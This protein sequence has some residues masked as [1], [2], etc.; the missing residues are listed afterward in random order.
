[1]AYTNDIFL[2]GISDKKV[3]EVKTRIISTKYGL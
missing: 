2:D 1:M 3:C